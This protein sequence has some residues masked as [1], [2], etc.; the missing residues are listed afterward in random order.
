MHTVTKIVCTRRLKR[1]MGG[2]FAISST[3]IPCICSTLP[4]LRIYDAI[5]NIGQHISG[6]YK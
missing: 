6:K 4:Y 2:L 3:A 1:R 5:K